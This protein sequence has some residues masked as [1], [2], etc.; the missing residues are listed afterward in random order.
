MCMTCASQAPAAAGSLPALWAWGSAAG[1]AVVGAARLRRR[2]GQTS[3]DLEQL[4]RV[5]GGPR[6]TADEL[7]SG[8]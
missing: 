4:A 1:V 6:D 5:G 2:A 3:D 7:P 8:E